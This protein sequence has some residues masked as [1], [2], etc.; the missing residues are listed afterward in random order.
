MLR[1]CR[2]TVRVI[3]EDVGI[4]VDGNEPDRTLPDGTHRRLFVM[5]EANLRLVA[6]LTGE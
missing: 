1:R 5:E 3:L 4:R 6:S 2:S